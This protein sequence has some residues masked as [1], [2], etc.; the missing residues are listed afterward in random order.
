[1]CTVA[2]CF[3]ELIGFETHMYLIEKDKHIYII[4]TFCGPDAMKEILDDIGKM[5]DKEVVV[6]N[7][8]FHWDHIWGN[9]AFRGSDIIAHSLCKEYIES[10]W[11]QQISNNRHY[12]MGDIK[13]VLPNI[14]VD[15][16]LELEGGIKIF[17]TPGHTKDS[18][19]IFD[20]EM[21]LLIVG[22][23][24]ELPL[25][26]IE[27]ADISGYIKSLKKYLD[28]KPVKITA[29]HTLE[30]TLEAIKETIIYLEYILK[31]DQ[32]IFKE[33]AMNEIHKKNMNVYLKHI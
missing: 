31:D 10:E 20:E 27:D 11:E 6:I 29:G 8:H 9:C 16:Q 25:I 19:S 1:M 28:L 32:I 17:H 5:V 24:L 14:L 21:G 12:I 2:Y 7:T 4:D 13:M 3:N 23:N 18:L 30:L 26:Y 22:D 15:E 33:K